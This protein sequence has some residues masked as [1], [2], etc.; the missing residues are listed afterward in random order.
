MEPSTRTYQKARSAAGYAI[1]DL[2]G[3]SV[4]GVPSG[5]EIYAAPSDE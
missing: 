5:D 1:Y 3:Q 2:K 4:D